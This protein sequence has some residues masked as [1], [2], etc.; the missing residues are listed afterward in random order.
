MKP[1]T[2]AAALA[3]IVGIAMTAGLM[4]MSTPATTL[5]SCPTYLIRY[6]THDTAWAKNG[7]MCRSSNRCAF[8]VVKFFQLKASVVLKPGQMIHYNTGIPKTKPVKGRGYFA[9]PPTQLGKIQG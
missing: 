3:T 7:C 5:P 2:K 4:T 6:V 9:Y 8:Y 1:V